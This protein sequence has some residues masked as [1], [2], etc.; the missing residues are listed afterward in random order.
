MSFLFVAAAA[1]VNAQ[2]NLI[3]ANSAGKV[4]LGMTIGEVR[5]AVAPM[6]LSR[7]SDGE[8]IALI[9]V[10]HGKTEVMTI[11]AGEE[12]RDAAIDDTAR[13]GQIWVWSRAYKTAA[14][15]HPGM[16]VSKAEKILGPVKEII[17][18]EIESREFAEFADQPSGIH[19]RL[20][21]G[22]GDFLAGSTRTTKYTA[23]ARI[24]S[25]NVVGDSPWKDGGAFSSEFTDLLTGC[26]PVGGEEG[27]HVSHFCKGP[28]NYQIHYFDAATV[29]QISVTTT[30]REWEEPL[31]MIGLDKLDGVGNVEW[32]LADGK[33][34][35]VLMRKPGAE[36][37]IVRGLKGFEQIKFEESG[38]GA[39]ERARS[40]ADNDHED[41]IVPSTRL[42]L[43]KSS[44]ETI[45]APFLPAG[46][47]PMH[48]ILKGD[49]GGST[50]NIVVLH[51]NDAP[52]VSYSGFVLIPKG[53]RFEKFDLPRP[54][55]NWSIEEPRAVFF[56][57]A[58]SDGELELFVIGECYTGIGRTGAR[59]FYRTRV[60]DRQDSGFVH[61]ENVSA[62]IGTLGTAS[63]IRK[64][65][66]TIVERLGAKL[67]TMDVDALNKKPRLD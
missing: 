23:S 29:Y 54:E 15:V 45:S 26:T 19:F 18:R 36:A 39:I 65:L 60:Y 21:S 28:G 2:A 56:A 34:F 16:P 44:L 24:F 37:V 31:M 50:G 8:G 14:G 46:G 49:F 40:V 53:S 47:K 59:P 5:K 27:G 6:K 20:N 43:S 25:I 13:V 55:F 4:K 51:G 57:N 48:E 1:S 66:P 12:D 62:K 11:Y 9:A 35:A 32:R 30:D 10:K 61:L 67:M 58:D 41:V 22:D 17:R 63:A 42:E 3:T 52:A 33:P 38:T 7:T 64:R